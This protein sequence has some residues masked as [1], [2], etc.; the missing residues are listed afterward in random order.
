[1]GIWVELS[2]APSAD[3][4]RAL[5]DDDTNEFLARLALRCGMRR[6]DWRHKDDVITVSDA[7]LNSPMAWEPFVEGL[8]AAGIGYD[9]VYETDT[10]GAAHIE[11]WRPGMERP[12]TAPR[13]EGDD[14]VTLRDLAAF[15]VRCT[16]AA[17][18][19]A[20]VRHHVGR[21]LPGLGVPTAPLIGKVDPH[22]GRTSGV[23]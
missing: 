9:E 12:V 14:A 19:L 6:A 13:V 1:M 22:G 21:D 2:F 17:E 16:D 11:R 10:F 23:A 15:A 7:E 5:E 3:I 20:H 8:R 4:A 18:L